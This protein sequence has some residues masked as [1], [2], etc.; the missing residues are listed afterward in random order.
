MIDVKSIVQNRRATLARLEPKKKEHRQRAREI[1]QTYAGAIQNFETAVAVKEN[2]RVIPG[3]F[4]TPTPLGSHMAG[5]ADLLPGDSICEPEA[6]GGAIAEVIRD[7]GFSVQCIEY[8]WTLC[9]ILRKKGFDPICGDFLEYQGH[10]DKFVMNPPFENFQDIDHICHAYELLNAGG[11]IV[12]IVSNGALHTDRLKAK[13]FQE[14]LN[15]IGA[16]QE[17]LPTGTFEHSG[18][19]VNACLIV[20]DKE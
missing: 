7:L 10:H 14:W 13:A 3:F 18:T 16:Y 11:R 20:I 17:D 12:S 19:M 9:E 2:I 8:N 5:L 1:S 4:P 15:G 6:G